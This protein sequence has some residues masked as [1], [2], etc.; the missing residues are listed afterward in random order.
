M[1]ASV[2][3]GG[4]DSMHVSAGTR[5]RLSRLLIELRR[6][7]AHVPGD[8][9]DRVLQSVV[10]DLLGRARFD[11]FV[12]LLAYRLVREQLLVD[13]GSSQPLLT[14]PIDDATEEPTLARGGM[15]TASP[16]LLTAT[17]G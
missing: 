9:V 4:M 1:R 16:P 8:R 11:D 5:R 2:R 6:E 7:F 14:L 15:R 13:P 17:E 12:P 3:S 10:E